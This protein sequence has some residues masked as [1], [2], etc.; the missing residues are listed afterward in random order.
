MPWL[1]RGYGV[2]RPGMGGWPTRGGV[3][4]EGEQRKTSR[5]LTVMLCNF[6]YFFAKHVIEKLPG[7]FV[8]FY[9]ALY[10]DW[11][12]HPKIVCLFSCHLIMHFTLTVVHKMFSNSKS[13][14]LN[15][16]SK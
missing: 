9:Y 7:H 14:Q 3:R 8:A 15:C 16:F 1:A 5:G 13:R 10:L 12:G 2:S 6:F 11:T 4:A